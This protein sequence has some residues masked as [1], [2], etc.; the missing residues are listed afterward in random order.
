MKSFLSRRYRGLLPAKPKYL[1]LTLLIF[2]SAKASAQ[3]SSDFRLTNNPANS[4]TSPNN[5]W[6]VATSGNF[7]HVV[8]YDERD[9]NK[10]IYYK[11]SAD[12]GL[13]WGADTRLT[14]NFALSQ[15]P[16]VAV[17]GQ[18]VNIAWTDA[19]DGDYEIYYKRS[20]DDGTTWGPDTRLTDSIGASDYPCITTSGAFVHVV[21]EDNRDGN[22]EI[23]YKSS[24]DGGVSWGADMRLTNN[25]S[26]ASPSSIAV[27]DSILHVVWDD[28][29]DGNIE[30]Y[31]KRSTDNGITWGADTRLTYDPDYSG[32]ASV[33]VS[34]LN[35]SVVWSDQRDGFLVNE[36]YY[37]SSTDG[38]I[39]WGADTRLTYANWV[40]TYPS[41]SVSGSNVHVVWNDSRDWGG[42]GWFEIYGKRSTDGGLNWGIDTRLTND[43]EESEFSSVTVSGPVVHVVWTDYRDGNPEIYYKR[44]ST[45]NTVG[46][47]ELFTNNSIHIYPNPS[48]ADIT[49]AFSLFKYLNI[50]ISIVDMNGRLIQ[51][52]ADNIFASGE[53]MLSWNAGNMNAGIYFLRI[54]SRL[55]SYVE[56]VTVIK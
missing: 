26:Y 30:I 50:S 32:N 36:I 3:W 28:N 22:F 14:N 21:W 56:K 41:V 54:D 2:I 7:I 1:F 27:S 51:T 46:L 34:G 49:I 43:Q 55:G 6:C 11:R 35:V 9:G 29:R 19:R 53:N 16:S 13:T 48:A 17:S 10:E 42:G 47:D 37:K 4:G 12:N 45:G 31:Y 44:D 23:Y 8:W 33:A 20:T 5:A 39:T 52:L 18:V 40:A 25:P 38:G 15:F 24:V